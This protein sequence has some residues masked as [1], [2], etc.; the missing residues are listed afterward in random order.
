LVEDTRITGKLLSHLDA[1]V[2]M[3]R[4]DDHTSDRERGQI[5][6]SLGDQA[7]ALM[8]ADGE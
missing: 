4:Y 1:K 7:I 8:Y 3:S 6:G 5:V 2:P